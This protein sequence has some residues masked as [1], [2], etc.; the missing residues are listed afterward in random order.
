M[1]EPATNRWQVNACQN[2]GEFSPNLGGRAVSVLMGQFGRWPLKMAAAEIGIPP[3]T[4]KCWKE[5][6]SRPS[7]DHLS[8][9]FSRFGAPFRCAVLAPWENAD[10]APHNLALLTSAT[11]VSSGEPPH[12]EME[13]R[14]KR[15]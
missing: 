9:L 6:R 2:P 11:T 7:T 15:A 3:D 1:S 5:G 10:P 8:R 4:W 14:L 12:V 13:R